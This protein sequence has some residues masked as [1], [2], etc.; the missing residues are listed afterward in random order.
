MVLGTE[1]ER[2]REGS[3]RA[4]LNLGC[5]LWSLSPPASSEGV[6]GAHCLLEVLL[7]SVTEDGSET[8]PTVGAMLSTVGPEQPRRKEHPAALRQHVDM[9]APSVLDPLYFLI[10]L[11]LFPSAFCARCL[12][13]CFAVALELH[14][15][16]MVCRILPRVMLL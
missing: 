8:K 7:G 15:C 5:F 6:V 11:I 2:R 14:V 16:H 12:Q 4:S 9:S 3:G 10:L 13:L 1:L